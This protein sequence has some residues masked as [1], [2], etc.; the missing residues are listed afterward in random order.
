MSYE[1]STHKNLFS[2]FSNIS[3]SAPT[4]TVSLEDHECSWYNNA[5]TCPSD[6]CHWTCDN[7]NNC[8]CQSKSLWIF[9]NYALPITVPLLIVCYVI[10][11]KC[12]AI[13]RPPDQPDLN[14]DGNGNA[15]DVDPS[16]KKQVGHENE[17]LLNYEQQ[18]EQDPFATN[19]GASNDTYDSP[20][21][22]N[23]VNPVINGYNN[24]GY[25]SPTSIPPPPPPPTQTNEAG[26]GGGGGGYYFDPSTLPPGSF[27]PG[28]AAPPPPPENN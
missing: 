27:L 23:N 17:K 25:F 5:T 6:V 12:K 18:P 7:H 21:L 20:G 15:V 28:F 1:A 10:Y 24:Y 22:N 8:K 11:K 13:F 3:T 16:A 14:D 4:T 26:N 19:Y 2:L 9:L